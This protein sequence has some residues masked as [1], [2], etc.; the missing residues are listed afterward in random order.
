MKQKRALS[1]THAKKHL[2]LSANS[3][4]LRQDDA[5][6][7]K[8]SAKNVGILLAG[9]LVS[10][11]LLSA[12]WITVHRHNTPKMLSVTVKQKDFSYKATYYNGATIQTSRGMSYL[13]NRDKN[14]IETSLWVA[15]IDKILS[16][17]DNATF[18]Y[19]SDVGLDS[20]SS[21]YSVDHKI[22][23]SDVIVDDQ[24]YQINMT[25]PEPISTSDAKQIFSTVDIS[26]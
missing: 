10:I 6:S 17:G 13:V 24:V 7:R 26:P 25:S 14:G 3:I 12:G 4:F 18:T 9:L 16:C 23:V 11:G 22:F 15:K 19:S 2:W 1:R 21:C 5:Y 20:R 8:V